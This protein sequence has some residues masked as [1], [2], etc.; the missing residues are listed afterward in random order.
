MCLEEGFLLPNGIL[1]P[2]K[3]V[4]A[5]QGTNPGWTP[6]NIP[7]GFFIANLEALE[8]DSVCALNVNTAGLTKVPDDSLPQHLQD[9][10]DGTVCL[11]SGQKAELHIVLLQYGPKS[12]PSV[13]KCR[14]CYKRA[15]LNHQLVP[16]QAPLYWSVKK[17]R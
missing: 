4:A 17:N 6:I 12:V 8:G 5:V 7:S 15:L 13:R 14:L 10:L 16:G 1:S 3:N 9:M 11:T 2:R